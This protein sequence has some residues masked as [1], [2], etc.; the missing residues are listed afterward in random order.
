MKG[1]D[2][3][4]GKELAIV[5][6]VNIRGVTNNLSEINNKSVSD[7]HGHRQVVLIWEKILSQMKCLSDRAVIWAICKG[8]EN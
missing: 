3:V 1:E 4:A 5:S 8:T 2:K 7:H 6:Y